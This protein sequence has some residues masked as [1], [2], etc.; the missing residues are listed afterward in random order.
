MDSVKSS[1]KKKFP[2]GRFLAWKTS[3]ISAAGLN[4]IV[5]TYLTIYCTNYLGVKMCIRDRPYCSQR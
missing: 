3:D 4:I 2:M 1:A 5:T